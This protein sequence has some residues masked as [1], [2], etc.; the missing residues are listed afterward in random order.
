MY[1]AADKSNAKWSFQIVPDAPK[2]DEVVETLECEALVVGAGLGGLSAACRLKEL[3]VESLVLEKSPSYS[4]RGG[5]FGVPNSSLMEKYGIVNDLEEVARQWIVM[6]GNNIDQE[7]LWTFLTRSKEAMDW[8]L[9]ITE[10]DGLAPRLVDCIY[11]IA[12][13]KEYYGAHSFP[14][15]GNIRGNYVS[16]ALYEHAKKLG[17]QCRFNTPVKQLI[18]D[19]TGRVCGAYA[20]GENGIIRI[21]AKYGVVLATGDIGGDEEMCRAYAPD[22]LRTLASEYVPAGCNTGDGHKMALWAGAAMAE[23]VFPLMMHPQHYAWCNYCSLFVNKNGKRFMNEDIYVQG[24]ATS[25]MRQPE[26]YC[27][28]ILSGDYAE[29]VMDSLKYGG[30]ILWGNAGL[31]YG[32]TL[33]IATDFL[34]VERALKEGNALKADTIEELADLMDVDKDEF[35]KTFA[36]YNELCEKGRDTQF[37]KRKELLYPLKDGPFYAVKI[38]ADL[39]VVVGGVS[40]DT[41]MHALDKNKKPIDGLFA[42]GDT[43]G[44]IYGHEY[45]TT[46]LGNSHGR[47]LTWGYIA[48]ETIAAEK[49]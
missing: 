18:K 31:K 25:V 41:K 22:A 42:V 4:G 26:G 13:Y 28:S 29:Q 21:N 49:K 11:P 39:L 37:G 7:L 23:E 32:E 30:G 16:K 6:S 1:E 34:S 35:L 10:A 44:G 17:I 9:P 27:Y 47:A 14:P 8:L 20:Q 15:K 38:G 12:P 36:E 5:H 43:T 40:I 3:G 48:A 24:R 2:R 33:N 45:V 46:I 19:D